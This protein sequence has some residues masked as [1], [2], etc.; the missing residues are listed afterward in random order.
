MRKGESKMRI[1]EEKYMC[2]WCCIKLFTKVISLHDLDMVF[3][4]IKA[5]F[6][7]ADIFD[8]DLKVVALD[9]K[10]TPWGVFFAIPRNWEKSVEYRHE[11]QPPREL[12]DILMSQF[13]THGVV[14]DKTLIADEPSR[15]TSIGEW[16]R[17]F[18]RKCAQTKRS[19]NWI[20]LWPFWQLRVDGDFKDD[21]LATLIQVY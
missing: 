16:V 13:E 8:S 4:S 18:E 12:V 5:D 20:D 14:K 7:G 19:T 1:I 17:W 9:N 6:R 11:A 3:R 10:V 21:D 2:G 15:P